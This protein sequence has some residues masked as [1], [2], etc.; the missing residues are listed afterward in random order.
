MKTQGFDR[1]AVTMPDEAAFENLA[2]ATL[3]A[4]VKV[5]QMV[6][7]RDGTAQR[8]L[9][10]AFRV[11]DQPVLEAICAML[12]GKTAKQKNPHRPGTLA[13]ATWVCAR[14]GGWTGY[15]GKPGPIVIYAG[16]ARFTAM[17][18]GWTISRLQ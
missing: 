11:E 2:T 5:M 17:L 4:A 1:E 7:D 3:I 9:T 13:Y 10:E 6:H 18:D 15:D 12:E 16:L 8:P 14:L